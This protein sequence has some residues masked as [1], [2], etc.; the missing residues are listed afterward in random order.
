MMGNDSPKLISAQSLLPLQ[1]DQADTLFDLSVPNEEVCRRAD[2]ERE[3]VSKVHQ[4]IEMVGHMER[5]KSTGW[6]EGCH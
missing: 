5:I 4:S 6:L 1:V 2:M 3:L